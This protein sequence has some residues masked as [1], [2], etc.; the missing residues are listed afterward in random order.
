MYTP[1]FEKLEEA[2]KEELLK[3]IRATKIKM[4]RLRKKMEHPYYKYGEKKVCPSDLV[5]YKCDREFLNMAILQY[6]SL[7]GEYKWSKTEIKDTEFDDNLENINKIIFYKGSCFSVPKLIEIDLSGEKLKIKR[8]IFGYACPIE[9]QTKES[10]LQEFGKLHI[11][12]WRKSYQTER[13]GITILDGEQWSL[14]IKYKDGKRT[15]FD[16]SNAYP[17]NFQELLEVLRL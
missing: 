15:T 16:G 6:I 2:S 13:F 12:E 11:G 14:K 7:G 8:G 10:F 1:P 3:I 5:I 9:E 17:Y 4:G